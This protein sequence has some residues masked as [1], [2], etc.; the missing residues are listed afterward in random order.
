MIIAAVAEVLI[1]L[2]LV[3]I[4]L[5]RHRY[6]AAAEAELTRQG[7]RPAVQEESGM[8]CHAGGHEPW[9]PVGMALVMTTLAVLNPA[10]N[11][12]GRTLSWIF[13][14]PLAYPA[15]AGRPVQTTTR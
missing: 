12:W 9:A 10:G 8:R 7:V 3:G 1:A 14:R 11:E 5:V 2:A 13:R 4:A 15:S 6:G